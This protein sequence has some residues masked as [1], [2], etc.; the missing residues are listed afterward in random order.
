VTLD[1]TPPTIAVTS[2]DILSPSA[3]VTVQLADNATGVASAQLDVDGAKDVAETEA[4]QTSLSYRPLYSGWSTGSHRIT[5][6][7]QDGVGNKQVMTKSFTVST[8]GSSGGGTSGATGGPSCSKAAARRAI[9]GVPSFVRAVRRRVY[10]G[11]QSLFSIYNTQRVI[12]RDLTGDGRRDM[13]VLMFCCTA[14]S[15]TPVAI[16]RNTGSRWAYAFGSTR[17]LVDAMSV[18]GH[19]LIELSPVYRRS[20]A[21]CC[22]SSHRRHRLDW[23]GHRFVSRRAR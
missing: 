21:F 3:A 6:T 19:D 13:A 18:R 20:D 7:A 16:F 5:V 15:P 14:A 11:K 9:L 2:P 10:A 8:S 22:P 23:T 1:S 12:C 17:R 4:G